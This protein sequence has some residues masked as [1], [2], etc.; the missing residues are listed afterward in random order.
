MKSASTR[1]GIEQARA[2]LPALVDEAHAGRGSVITRHGKPVAALVSLAQMTQMAQQRRP[3]G[4]LAL[5][6]SGV[7][8]WSEGAARAVSRLRGEWR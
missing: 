4:L 3:S 1:I 7:G 2:S 8:L 6:G 5:R